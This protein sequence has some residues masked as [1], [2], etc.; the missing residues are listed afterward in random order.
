MYRASNPRTKVTEERRRQLVELQG[1]RKRARSTLLSRE[2]KRQIRQIQDHFAQRA[3]GVPESALPNLDGIVDVCGGDDDDESY[4]E[5]SEAG[6]DRS[7]G[8]F[9][10][11]E[12]QVASGQLPPASVD[13]DRMLVSIGPGSVSVTDFVAWATPLL[14]AAGY[15]VVPAVSP[16]VVPAVV[17]TV[18]PAASPV[19]VPA[20]SP[21]AV[22]Q[23][24]RP[25][26]VRKPKRA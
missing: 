17:S 3:R 22:P 4:E 19:V 5:V 11:A 23:V 18:S 15:A 9:R 21:A 20:V 2:S 8:N 10:R 1:D 24:H 13:R 6:V 25:T 16:V 26:V 7:G 14:S 12:V